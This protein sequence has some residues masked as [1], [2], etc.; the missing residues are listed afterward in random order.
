MSGGKV[1]TASLDDRTHHGAC[2]A[3][4]SFDLDPNGD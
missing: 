3:A 2:L 4:V 1:D